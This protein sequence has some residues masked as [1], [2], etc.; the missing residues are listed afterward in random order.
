MEPDEPMYVD[1]IIAHNARLWFRFAC[2]LAAIT[3]ALVTNQIVRS[4][5]PPQP[6]YVLIVDGQGQPVGKVEPIMSVQAIPNALLKAELGDFIHDAFTISR[7]PDEENLIFD[8]TQSRV[9]GAA[10]TALN[11]WY[12]RDKDKHDPRTSGHYAPAE[13]LTQ[14]VLKLE[15]NSHYQVDYKLIAHS[16]EDSTTTNWRATMHVIVGRSKDP[17]SVGF[18]IDE[19]D[20]QQVG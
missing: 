2:G 10:F 16:G 20:F 6:P 3:V 15:G 13:A 17:N 19:L 11:N 14:D 18:Y 9:T 7:D 8:R 4:W 5:Q 12:Q 1:S